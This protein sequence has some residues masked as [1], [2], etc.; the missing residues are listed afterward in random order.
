MALT[1]LQLPGKDEFYSNLQTVATNMKRLMNEW[2]DAA[3][4]I[5]D[6]DTNDLDTMGVPVG[7]VRTDLVD[8]RTILNEVHD[9]FTGTATT[10]TKIPK[11][12]VDKIRRMR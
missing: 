11:N 4:F 12:I 3:D 10:Q 6:V 8:L 9:F 5:E 1:E 7:Q 2:R